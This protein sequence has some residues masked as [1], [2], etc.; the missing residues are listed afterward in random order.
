VRAA[1]IRAAERTRVDIIA[2]VSRG[3]TPPVA[4]KII[5]MSMAGAQVSCAQPFGA[6][7][8]EVAIAF[9]LKGVGS[10]SLQLTINSAIRRVAPMADNP[11]VYDHGVQFLAMSLQETLLV[12]NLIYQKL[13]EIG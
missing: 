11:N 7:G 3:D 4:A 1:T 8:D 6:V 5:D 13:L 10:E 9:R 12:Q 2:S